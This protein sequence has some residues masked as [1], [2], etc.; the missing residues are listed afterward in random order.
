MFQKIGKLIV[1]VFIYMTST[2]QNLILICWGTPRGAMCCKRAMTRL[3]DVVLSSIVL[4]FKL[5]ITI[6]LWVFFVIVT[7]ARSCT[8]ST[9]KCERGHHQGEVCRYHK[10][11]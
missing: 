1:L 10:S 5:V 7:M 6:F 11:E 9:R 4:L 2:D 3:D 8:D